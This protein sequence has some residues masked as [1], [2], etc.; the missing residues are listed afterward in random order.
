MVQAGVDMG[1]TAEQAHQLA[2]GTFTGAS[3]LA[4]QSTE[5]P[6]V[7]RERVTSKGGT[8]FAALESLRAANVGP[9]FINAMKAAEKR[10]TELGDEFGK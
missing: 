5:P 6:A 8:T 3:Q 10:A 2:V 4:A 1:L 7:L 9:H